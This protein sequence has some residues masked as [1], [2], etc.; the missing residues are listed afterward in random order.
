MV[1]MKTKYIK[2]GKTF[3][4]SPKRCFI[5]AEAGSNHNG[6]F[7]TAKRL[8][9]AAKKSG[10]DAVKFQ[11]FRAEELTVMKN[12]YGVLRK[13]EFERSWLR[14]LVRYAEK[15]GIVFFATPFD[16]VAVD[17]LYEAGVTVFKVASSD[18]TNTPLLKSIAAKKKPVIMSV[19]LANLKEIDKAVNIILDKGASSLSLL[20]CVVEYPARIEDLNLRAIPFLVQRFGLPVGFSDHTMDTV[21]PS[22][23]VSLG[24]CIVEKHFTLSRKMKG[25]DHPFALEPEEF[26]GM[27]KNIRK[28]ELSLGLPAKKLSRHERSITKIVRRGIYSRTHIPGGALLE[29]SLLTVLRPQKGVS[30][31]DYDKVI[32]KRVKKDIKPFKPLRWKDIER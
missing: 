20:H 8:I 5:I 10:A 19:G 29:D 1:K 6:D 31:S 15:R 23:A 7:R 32:G 24:A 21:I 27:A 2:I 17:L 25:P 22:I 26:A 18:L 28:A 12:L 3:I 16:R 4:G 13:C 11:L 9:D 30:S 14:K